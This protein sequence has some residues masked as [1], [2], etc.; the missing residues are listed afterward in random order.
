MELLGRDQFP[1]F[2][3]VSGKLLVA[4]A[5]EF[6]TY[7]ARV[8]HV[9]RSIKLFW[10]AFNQSSLNPDSCGNNNCDVAVVVVIDRA[11]RKDLFLHEE[12]RFAVGEF[13]PSLR[14][15]ETEAAH[16]LNMFLFW[17]HEF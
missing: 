5:R 3:Q 12:R 8:A 10:I 1:R 11:H 4:N 15:S 6:D 13:F 9:R 2:A 17:C 16:P 14:Q 7:P